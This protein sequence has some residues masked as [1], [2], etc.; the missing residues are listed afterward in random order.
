M[1]KFINNTCTDEELLAVKHWLDESDE[2]VTKLFELENMA[3]LAGTL[4]S[5]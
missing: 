5:D 2:N 4:R 3:M 1:I